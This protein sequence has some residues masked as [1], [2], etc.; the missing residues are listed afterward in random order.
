MKVRDPPGVALDEGLV[1]Q[2]GELMNASSSKFIFAEDYM[3]MAA[4][5]YD[6][7]HL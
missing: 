5:L 3:K 6:R 1:V 7:E 2:V 4:S